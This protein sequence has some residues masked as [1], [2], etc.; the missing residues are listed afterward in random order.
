[1]RRWLVLGVIALLG[2]ITAGLASTVTVTETVT[3]TQLVAVGSGA[4]PTTDASR[5]PAA[6]VPLEVDD[7]V[8]LRPETVL[9]VVTVLGAGAVLARRLRGRG[10]ER[11]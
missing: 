11:G 10:S 6:S 2:V 1:M 5:S 4:L 9:P 3:E 7:D 8:L